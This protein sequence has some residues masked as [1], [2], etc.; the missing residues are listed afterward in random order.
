MWK[1]LSDIPLEVPDSGDEFIAESFTLQ[2]IT[3]PDGITRIELWHW[4]D[5]DRKS[6][7]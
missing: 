6:V 4:F 7:V 3:F 5:E 1:E 2:G